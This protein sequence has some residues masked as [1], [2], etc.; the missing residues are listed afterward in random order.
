MRRIAGAL[1]AGEPS[2][3]G[4]GRLRSGFEVLPPVQFAR[5]PWGHQRHRA[6]W[7]DRACA[8]TSGRGSGSVGCAA[9]RGCRLMPYFLLEIGVE[10]VPDWMIEPALADLRARWQA[11]F[12]AFECDALI[13]DATPRRLVLLAKN[14]AEQAPDVE[15]VVQGPYLSAGK[16]A[17]EGF[18]RKW[19]TSIN[20]LATS[21]D[22]KGER[23]IFHQLV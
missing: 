13:T 5:C 16:Q 18:A 3:S 7:R 23:Y 22:T 2:L 14:L 17:A 4:V 12:G 8:Q 15:S 1:Q 10:E 11:A 19:N 9:S 21:Q 6:R 20:A